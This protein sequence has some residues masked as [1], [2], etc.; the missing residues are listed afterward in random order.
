MPNGLSEVVVT[1]GLVTDNGAAI[2]VKGEVLARRD[3]ADCTVAA[4]TGAPEAGGC[5]WD[6]GCFVAPTA[7]LP[8]APER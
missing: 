6:I 7:P 8:A 2:R 5:L 1:L 3:A 4:V